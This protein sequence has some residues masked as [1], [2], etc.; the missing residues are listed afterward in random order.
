[1]VLTSQWYYGIKKEKK[2][3]KEKKKRKEK[4]GEEE[5][6]RNTSGENFSRLED[7]WA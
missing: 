3:E 6:R 2:N 7:S 1:M 4:K 5:K